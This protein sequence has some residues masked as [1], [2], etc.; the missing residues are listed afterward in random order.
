MRHPNP[1]WTSLG[2]TPITHIKDLAGE[3]AAFLS[4]SG[5]SPS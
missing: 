1:S 3:S 2:A 5:V 4:L